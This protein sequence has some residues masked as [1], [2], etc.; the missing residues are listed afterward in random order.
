MDLKDLPMKLQ[1]KLLAGAAAMA[2]CGAAFAGPAED[3]ISR[4]KCSK[5]HTATTTKKAPSW[6]DVAARNK[7]KPDAEARLLNTLKTGKA[8]DGEEHDPGPIKG[9]DADLKAVVQIVLSSK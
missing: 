3:I 6:A 7:G 2:L 9:S 5:C 4:E 1:L 8:S